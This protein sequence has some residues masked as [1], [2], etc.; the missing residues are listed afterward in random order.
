MAHFGRIF[1]D[2]SA[3]PEFNRSAFAALAVR[4][5]TVAGGSLFVSSVLLGAIKVN[6]RGSDAVTPVPTLSCDRKQVSR[7]EV[8]RTLRNLYPPR[9]LQV[10]AVSS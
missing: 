1:T 9:V 7:P 4:L 8:V 5:A 10:P 3:R 6:R 2:K